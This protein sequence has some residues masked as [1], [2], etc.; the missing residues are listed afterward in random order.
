M[1][2]TLETSL[3]R[4]TLIIKGRLD[5]LNDYT[6]ACRT[7]AVVG[8][9]C[10][11]KNED[12][13]VAAILEQLN[14]VRFE[15]R[16]YMHFRWVEANRKRDLDNVCFAKKFILDA[17]VRCGVIETDGWKGVYGFTDEFDVEPF[18]PRIEVM[19]EGKLK[20]EDR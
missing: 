19:I 10:K 15:G 4:R 6:K 20:G 14:G 5:A 11:R 1:E 2:R 7:K 16:T 12:I 3:T 8:A 18:N 17:L 9:N 13:I